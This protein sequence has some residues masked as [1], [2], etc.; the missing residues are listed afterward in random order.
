MLPP[1]TAAPFA[2][3]VTAYVVAR[4]SAAD[5]VNVTTPVVALKLDEPATAEPP[6]VTVIARRRR[7]R[8][9]R[10]DHC[11]R[12]V[13]VRR[14]AAGVLVVIDGFGSVVNDHVPP[15]T[16]SP[17]AVSVTA[18]R[19]LTLQR[20]R[21]CERH[22]AGRRVE[23]RRTRDRGTTGRDRDR[24][25]RCVRERRRDHGRSRVDV[26]RTRS[27]CLRGEGEP[28]TAAKVTS[29]STKYADEFQELVGKPPCAPVGEATVVPADADDVAP[30][31]GSAK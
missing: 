9:R 25:R 19:L 28:G 16:D 24:T 20:G 31:D 7:I 8:E 15:V 29:A 5:G 12:G 21:R 22:D 30:R 6:A 11:R 4:C 13:D 14:V 3:A 17:F 18:V 27:G 23:V 10:R 26:R 2:V 1:V